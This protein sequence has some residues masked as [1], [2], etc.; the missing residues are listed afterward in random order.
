MLSK[1]SRQPTHL[2]III[3]ARM[4]EL[5]TGGRI[6]STPLSLIIGSMVAAYLLFSL[7]FKNVI[8]ESPF[9]RR[10]ANF[11]MVPGMVV[12]MLV[13]WVLGE[14][15]L[16][17]IQWGITQPDFRL[18]PDYLIFAVG[19]PDLDMFLLAIPTAIIAYVIAFGDILVARASLIP[20][21]IK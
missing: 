11:G 12:A 6:D 21:E 19:A 4:G 7:S 3:A 14:H 17:H 9:A 2:G 8:E 10:I 18:M 5:K 1:L 20:T 15:P 16:P 13:G